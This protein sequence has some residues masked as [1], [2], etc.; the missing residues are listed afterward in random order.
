M[1]A[2]HNAFQLPD[3]RAR[4]WRYLTL[5]KFV[6]L[7]QRKKLFFTRVDRLG[8]DFEGSLPVRNIVT[9]QE[10]QGLHADPDLLSDVA[11]LREVILVNCW[12]MNRRESDALW[13]IYGGPDE[14]VA[15][16]S[17]VSRVKAAFEPCPHPVYV[18][19]VLYTDYEFGAIVPELTRFPFLFKRDTFEH[20]REVRAV[21]RVPS[22]PAVGRYIPV[23]LDTL[24]D[25][26]YVAPTAPD[27]VMDMVALLTAQ[28]DTPRPVKR[29]LLNPHNFPPD[30]SVAHPAPP[31][32][33]RPAFGTGRDGP[34][35]GAAPPA[36]P[37]GGRSQPSQDRPS[38]S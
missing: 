17:T 11:R 8:D 12:H 35:R 23:D 10:H 6:D 15:I 1:Y 19:Q 38:V 30:R 3:E 9:A 25:Q 34:G 32:D 21:I 2:A 33:A 13:R 29:S 37:P 18:G 14:A 27:W 31:G 36:P 4:L 26:I 5:A 22:A 28:Y 16:R 7:L 20:E 24:I